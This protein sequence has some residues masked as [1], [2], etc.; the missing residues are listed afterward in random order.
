MLENI[1]DYNCV[2]LLEWQSTIDSELDGIV[3]IF[4]TMDE[5]RD[6]ITEE[7]RD[8]EKD[9]DYVVTR[10]YLNQPY[11]SKKFKNIGV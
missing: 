11:S 9:I 8:G 3:G 5:V 1:E 2:Y 6:C 7:R 10:Y 4:S